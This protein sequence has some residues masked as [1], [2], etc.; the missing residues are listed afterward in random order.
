[1]HN[2]RRLRAKK[3][4][5]HKNGGGWLYRQKCLSDCWLVSARASLR[6]N[7]ESQFACA[8]A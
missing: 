6:K 7:L 8:Y 3:V 1:M 2:A 5:D 4:S